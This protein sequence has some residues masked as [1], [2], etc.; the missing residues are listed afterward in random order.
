MAGHPDLS[1]HGVLRQEGGSL[2]TLAGDA[3]GVWLGGEHVQGPLSQ[4]PLR[5]VVV[6]QAPHPEPNRTVAPL[7]HGLIMSYSRRDKRE[8]FGADLHRFS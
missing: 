3:R 8:A 5:V 2:G 1:G 7:S 6:T 4:L